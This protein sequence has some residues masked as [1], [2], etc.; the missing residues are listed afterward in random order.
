MGVVLA[1]E[2]VGGRSRA[3]ELPCLYYRCYIFDVTD[4]IFESGDE[5][6]VEIRGCSIWA[7]EVIIIAV[8]IMVILNNIPHLD[9]IGSFRK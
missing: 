4:V 2:P 6:E 3:T 1:S 9:R 5:E 8:M 7:V